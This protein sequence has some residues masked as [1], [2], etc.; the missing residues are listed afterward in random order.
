LLRQRQAAARAKRD[1][2][3]PTVPSTTAEE[4]ATNPYLRVD[5]PEVRAAAERHAGRT[6]ADRIAVFAEVR[7]WKNAF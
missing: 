6:L 4:R 3:E 2:G 5:E 7:A 1:P